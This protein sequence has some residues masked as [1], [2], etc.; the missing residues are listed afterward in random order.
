MVL[1]IAIRILCVS[2]ILA[3]SGWLAYVSF[4]TN[5]G[6]FSPIESAIKMFCVFLP[7][8]LILLIKLLHKD[9][10]SF[11]AG[12]CISVIPFIFFLSWY[13]YTGA[14]Y[15]SYA[16]FILGVP[17]LWIIGIISLFSKSMPN[18]ALNRTP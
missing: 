1:N 15:A 8:L 3:V 14:M 16:L 5:S 10:V 7:P 2:E 13:G 12:A 18:Q 6:A 17:L 4:K 11:E 9:K